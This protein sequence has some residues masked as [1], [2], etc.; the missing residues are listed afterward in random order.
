MRVT[1][2][3]YRPAEGRERPIHGAGLVA[4]LS[5]A[6]T[7]LAPIG[8]LLRR[9]EPRQKVTFAFLLDDGA[10]L[11]VAAGA[12]FAGLEHLHRAVTAGSLVQHSDDVIHLGRLG[13]TV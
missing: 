2:G 3:D 10:K 4:V 7:H 6:D 9:R 5:V 11:D 8:L 12:V 1:L 13:R